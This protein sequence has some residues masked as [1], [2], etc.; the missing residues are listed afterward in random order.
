M[1]AKAD[2]MIAKRAPFAK[3]DIFVTPYVPHQYYPWA[4]KSQQTEIHLMWGTDQVE[5]KTVSFHFTSS[6]KFVPGT[7]DTPVDSIENW[8]AIDK[9]IENEDIVG[10][11]LNSE[12][13]WNEGHDEKK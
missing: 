1:L 7:M 6:G 13:Q 8:L 12:T 2:S 11:P 9:S 10:P 5:E 3:H 4:V